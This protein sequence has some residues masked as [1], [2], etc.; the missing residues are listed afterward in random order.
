MALNGLTPSQIANI[1]LALGKNRWL[2]LLSQALDYNEQLGK[3]K[4][5]ENN[6]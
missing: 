3:T 5:I 1:E 4:A 6:K 2:G